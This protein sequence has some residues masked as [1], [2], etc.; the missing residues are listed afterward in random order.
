MDEHEEESCDYQDESITDG[1]DWIW[2]IRMIKVLA[3]F[4]VFGVLGGVIYFLVWVFQAF[5]K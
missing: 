1:E 4:L 3:G 2:E 5:I